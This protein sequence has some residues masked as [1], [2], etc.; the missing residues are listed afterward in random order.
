M[1]VRV[2]VLGAFEGKVCAGA[3]ANCAAAVDGDGPVVVDICAAVV[4][5]CAVGRRVVAMTMV[6]S[7]G[8]V[9]E[10]VECRFVEPLRGDVELASQVLH[11]YLPGALAEG[12]FRAMPRA[13]VVGEGLEAAQGAMDLLKKGVSAKKIV[14]T[15]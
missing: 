4:R 7:W 6:P 5:S 8:P 15:I 11:D 10:G 1:T 12:S 9:F 3:V 14:V 2:D 13:E